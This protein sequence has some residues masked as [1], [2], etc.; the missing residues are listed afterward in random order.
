MVAVFIGGGV[1]GGLLGQRLARH[2]AGA[3]GSCRGLFALIVAMVGIYVVAR[4][5]MTL[6]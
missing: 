3:R 6:A 5:V 2:L 4:G 1:I